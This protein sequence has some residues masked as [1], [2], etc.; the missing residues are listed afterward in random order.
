MGRLFCAM[1]LARYGLLFGCLSRNLFTKHHFD[2]VFPVPQF[3]FN[4]NYL[5]FLLW[6]FYKNTLFR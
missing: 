3:T 2:K 4:H 5:C 6:V 1:S